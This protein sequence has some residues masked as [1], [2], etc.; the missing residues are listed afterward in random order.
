[1][2]KGDDRLLI[3]LTEDATDP[4]EDFL[5]RNP[6]RSLV[7]KQNSGVVQFG[8][9]VE[10]A[11]QVKSDEKLRVR[12]RG[13][14]NLHKVRRFLVRPIKFFS[15]KMLFEDAITLSVSDLK[16]KINTEFE[17]LYQFLISDLKV[18]II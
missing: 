18:K 12:R 10:I 5:G 2:C 17:S 11:V 3:R 7:F 13:G 9:D 6:S 15:Q 4:L 8:A 16:I 14:K 1:M